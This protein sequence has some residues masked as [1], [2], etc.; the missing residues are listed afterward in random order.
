MIVAATIINLL[1]IWKRNMREFALVGVWALF[2]IFIRH[3][4]SNKYIAYAAI[5]GVIILFVVI[6]IHAMKNHETNP[7]K[8]LKERLS[9]K[10]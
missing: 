2:A 10:N 8:K 5:T 3:N 4:G 9:G 7:F 6:T 1:M